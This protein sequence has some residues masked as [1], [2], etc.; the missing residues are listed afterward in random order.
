MSL[1]QFAFTRLIQRR[2]VVKMATGFASVLTLGN[3]L[4][5]RNVSAHQPSD[6]NQKKATL[7]RQFYVPFNTGETSIYQSILAVNWTD[8]PLNPSKHLDATAFLPL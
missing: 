6:E 8:N 5:S 3:L 7:V 4:P 2:Y 1:S